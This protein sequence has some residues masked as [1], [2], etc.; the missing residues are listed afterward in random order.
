MDIDDLERLVKLMKENDLV[1]L[2]IEREGSVVRLKKAAGPVAFA[3]PAPVAA[4]MLQAA[5]VA[6]PA[7]APA[8]KGGL[9]PGVVEIK[10]PIVG[11]FYKAASPETPPFVSVGDRVGPETVVCI[12]EAMKVMNEIKAELS[13]EI[14]E[15][16]VDNGE[17]VEFDQPLFRVKTA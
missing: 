6:A 15:V 10:S 9:P 7:G 16:L 11:T 17:A 8:A 5:P 12:V 3:L 13:G 4:P 1:E 14:I 2:E